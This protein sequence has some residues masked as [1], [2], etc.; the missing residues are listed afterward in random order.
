MEEVETRRLECPLGAVEVGVD[1]FLAQELPEP[2]HQVQVGRIRRQKDLHEALVGQPGD[3][4]FVAVVAGVVADDIDRAFGV[5]QQ[6]LLV[7][8]LGTV[9][10]NA[11]RFI[12][13][14]LGGTAGV[15]GGVQ[16]HPLAAADREQRPL[17]A[18]LRSHVARADMV[19]RVGHIGKTDRRGPGISRF[20]QRE[21][22]VGQK[23]RLHGRIG[24]TG[25]D[26][27]PSI[28]V[29]QPVQQV[30]QARYRVGHPA[31]RGQ[32][33]HELVAF[34]LQRAVQLLAEPGQ[35]GAGQQAPAAGLPG[36]RVAAQALGVVGL[37]G[38]VHRGR[39]QA[40]VL[41]NGVHG[42]PVVEQQQH[43][44]GHVARLAM[45]TASPNRE[46]IKL[47]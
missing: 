3:H 15:E 13:V 19:G 40:Q 17:L 32:P 34:G 16:I 41:G 21:Q 8:A 5:G 7:A 36:L 10:I 1:D 23:S 28:G 30:G 9:G 20:Q 6:Q 4:A 27:G 37:G 29:A 46:G 42:P 47:S 45:A 11:V 38:A 44:H 26:R 33:V 39:V 14:D 24:R 31:S 18:R 35:L 2:L 25:H 43:R 12:R 22:G